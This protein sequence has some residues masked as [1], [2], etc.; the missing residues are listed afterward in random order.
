MKHYVVAYDVVSA[1]LRRKVAH[2]V[3]AYCVGGQKSVLEVPMHPSEA[4]D[5]ALKLLTLIDEKTDR[6]HIV[7]VEEN[8]ISLGSARPLK[9]E[10]GIVI[11]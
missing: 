5:L 3:Y 7:E 11:V 1:R 9:F 8:T 2:T 4:A 6:V 10:E